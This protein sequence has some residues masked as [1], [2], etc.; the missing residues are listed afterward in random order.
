M[1]WAGVTSD[2]R[3]PQLSCRGGREDR[4]G[5]IYLHLLSE[6]VVRWVQREYPT[7]FYCSN[8]MEFHPIPANWFKALH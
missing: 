3:R 2:G 8:K 7:L 5:G 1:V 6:E 4:P